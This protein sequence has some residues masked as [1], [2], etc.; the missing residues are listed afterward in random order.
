MGN[1]TSSQH[2]IPWDEIKLAYEI[3]FPTGIRSFQCAT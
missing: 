3:G 2:N 1:R